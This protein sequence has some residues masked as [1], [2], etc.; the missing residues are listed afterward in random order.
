MKKKSIFIIIGSVIL[1]GGIIAGILLINPK[2]ETPQTETDN[3]ISESTEDLGTTTNADRGASTGEVITN[4]TQDDS[5]VLNGEL[6]AE[7]P[8]AAFSSKNV[9]YN[10][11]YRNAVYTFTD[12]FLS[13]VMEMPQYSKFSTH[14]VKYFLNNFGMFIKDF[15][16]NETKEVYDYLNQWSADDLEVMVGGAGEEEN[17]A[18]TNPSP[19]VDQSDITALNTTMYSKG[20]VNVRKGPSTDYEK[21]GALTL[22]QEVKITGQSKSTGWYRIEFNGGEGYVSQNYLSNSKITTPA[23]STGSNG[24]SNGNGLNPDGTPNLGGADGHGN[25]LPLPG[26]PDPGGSTETGGGWITT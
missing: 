26:G 15:E 9:T 20:D 22:N 1:V 16:E 21:I 10:G 14:Q 17:I 2:S 6:T 8:Y 19:E 7:D 3:T 13:A 18:Q 4:T 12:D 11:D 23:P 24:G 5:T 25:Y